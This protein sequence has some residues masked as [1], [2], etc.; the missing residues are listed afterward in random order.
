[1]TCGV[2]H[3]APGLP[4]A[5][6]RPLRYRRPSPQIARKTPGETLDAPAVAIHARAAARHV[7]TPTAGSQSVSAADRRTCPAF[8]MVCFRAG[9]GRRA[10]FPLLG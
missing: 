6:R 3:P 2:P 5:L 4:E 10:R 7:P 1:M 8:S 9:Y